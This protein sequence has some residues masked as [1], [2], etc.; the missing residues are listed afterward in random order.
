MIKNVYKNNLS[1]TLKLL[2]G[3]KQGVHNHFH[4]G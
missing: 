3:N 2:R 1:C 4:A